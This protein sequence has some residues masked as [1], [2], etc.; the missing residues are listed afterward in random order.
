[1]MGVGLPVYGQ[2]D[3]TLWANA[4]GQFDDSNLYW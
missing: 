3:R 1:M 4:K 2:S